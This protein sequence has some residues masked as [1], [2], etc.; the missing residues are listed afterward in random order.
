MKHQGVVAGTVF[1]LM[2]AL[3][4][5]GVR[6]AD[7]QCME[8]H[9]KQETIV[10]FFH[11]ANGVQCTDCHGENGVMD[12]EALALWLADCHAATAEYDGNL[13]STSASRKR[14]LRSICAKTLDAIETGRLDARV[15]DPDAIKQRLA[16]A[17]EME[18]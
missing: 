2:L 10:S 17:A 4:S 7:S 5:A 6:A 11:E 15:R 13:K 3:A 14:R 16:R 18:D 12:W 1:S 9:E 8:C